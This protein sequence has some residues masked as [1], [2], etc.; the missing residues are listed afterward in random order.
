MIFAAGLG[1]RLR[2][3]TDNLPKALVPVDGKPMLERVMLKLKAAGFT[4]VVVNVHHFGQKIVDFL[5][6]KRNF[7]L[8][9]DISDEREKLLDTGGGIRKA[10][11]YFRG[12]APVLVHNVDILSDVDLGGFYGKHKASSAAASLWVS[13]RDTSRYLFFDGEDR[14]CGWENRKTG[15]VKSPFPDFCPTRY[16]GYAFGGIHVISPSLLE[17]MQD[18]DE[19]FSIIDFYLAVAGRVEIKACPASADSFWMDLGK[20]EAIAE[21]ECYLKSAKDGKERG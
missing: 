5:E 14:L 10:A 2:P 19:K 8:A 15:E 16:E 21:A 18:W 20:P 1:T 17:Q 4:H 13:K 6:E 12:N 7:G 3:L 11:R 9:V